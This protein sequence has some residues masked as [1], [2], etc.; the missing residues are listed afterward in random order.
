[1]KDKKSKTYLCYIV[2][3]LIIAA[4]LAALCWSLWFANSASSGSNMVTMISGWISAVA[5]TA[6]GIIALTQNN[7]L[8]KVTAKTDMRFIKIQEDIN[9]ALIEIK[10]IQN[11]K[12]IPL[13]AIFSSNENASAKTIRFSCNNENLATMFFRIRNVGEISIR[14]IF[15]SNIEI[16]GSSYSIPTQPTNSVLAVGEIAIIEVP[17]LK[18][19]RLNYSI[20]F[21]I[22]LKNVLGQNF[23]G[24][25]HISATYDTMFNTYQYNGFMETLPILWE[26]T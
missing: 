4:V 14:E 12:L 7:K 21:W 2:V 9:S 15:I 16:D 18:Q 8:A 5:T 20:D 11:S 23:I 24:Q 13:V 25:Y 26:A 3:P 6:L 1:M 22:G 10:K 19:S 17:I